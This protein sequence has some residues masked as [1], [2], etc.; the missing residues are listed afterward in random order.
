M[1]LLQRLK[2]FVTAPRPQEAEPPPVALPAE[3]P[4]RRRIISLSMVKNEQDIIEPFIR[5]NARFVDC[6]IILDNASVDE[7]RRI[8]MDCARELGNVIVTDNEEFGY[9]QAER[10]TR[11]LLGCQSVFRADF[12]LFLDA[13]EFISATDRAAL[14]D[15]LR[16][17]PSGGVG[18]MPWRNFIL[19][20]DDIEAAEQ[21]TPRHMR[22]RRAVEVPPFEKV[23]LRLD[24]ACR[25]DLFV[26]QG[27][28]NVVT[29]NGEALPTIALDDL[30]LLHFA[31][32]SRQQ[33]MT[34]GIVGWMAYLGK[35]PNARYA[36]DGLQ[37]RDAFDRAVAG[38]ITAAEMADLSMLYGQKRPKDIDWATDVV[39]DDPPLDYVR[40]YSSGTP[41]DPLMVVARSWER[42]LAT[43]AAWPTLQR[44][45]A[46]AG[47]P[48]A[49]HWDRLSV[50][51]APFRFIAEK[52]RPGSVL[53]LGCG[54][55]AHLVLFKQLVQ[56]HVFGV[57]TVPLDA[58]A[59]AGVEYLRH[60]PMQTFDLNRDFEMVIFTR[61]ADAG[62]DADVDGIVDTILRHVL[63]AIVLS[64][65]ADC[66]AASGWPSAWMT[67][68]AERGW[69]PDLYDSL[70]MRALATLP[71]L[72]RNLVLFRRA[73]AESGAAAAAALAECTAKTPV[74]PPHPPGIHWHAFAASSF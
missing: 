25:T 14:E 12:V 21:D 73:D 51:V 28:H 26:A 71:S 43:P 55:G 4:G 42:S 41:G 36:A 60:D 47:V 57:D 70:G 17:I 29:T 13:D 7:T 58:F 33:M 67:R 54:V 52:F 72:R 15:V 24:G 64:A 53:E 16:R 5:H 48:C 2:A 30:P 49:R 35:D 65:D 3:P 31:V 69:Y 63:D 38:E 34:K 27:N 9:L 39:R 44:P 22:H 11:A 46:A 20:P 56:S 45:A 19:A 18:R 6:M 50:D 62:D 32:R 59:L 61:P 1:P 68:L 66:D 74:F 40:T 10:M 8:A 23:V 37:W